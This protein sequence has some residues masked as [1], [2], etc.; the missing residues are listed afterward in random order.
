MQKL[1]RKL[2]PGHRDTAPQVPPAV[3]EQFA[4]RRR[5]SQLREI[6]SL[7]RFDKRKFIQPLP[8]I[9]S[10]ATVQQRLPA[11]GHVQVVEPTVAHLRTPLFYGAHAH[12]ARSQGEAPPSQ[13]AIPAPGLRGGTLQGPEI[14]DRLVVKSRAG[15][16]QL[17][18]R[19]LGERPLPGRRIYRD[20]DIEKPCQ[21][22]VY[23]P[24]EHCARS[25]VN[26]RADGRRS[27]VAHAGQRAHLPVRGREHPAEP[28]HDLPRGSMEVAGTAVIAQPLPQFEHLVLG[29]GCQCGDVGEPLRKAQVVLQSLRHAR[30][31]QDNLRKPYP[32]RVTRA[33]PGQV[34][35]FAGE[36]G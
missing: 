32:V 25:V 35:A 14:H 22:P 3:A 27:I 30:L 5:C 15:S 2:V 8:D 33:T 12:R 13:G 20:A 10:A 11:A 31:L 29:R 6:R 9:A 1:V 23:I 36:P 17:Q 18:L 24:V 28:R 19:Q 4:E 21:H 34:T 7:V 26:D 16:I